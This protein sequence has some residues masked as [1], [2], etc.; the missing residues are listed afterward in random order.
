M[1]WVPNQADWDSAYDLYLDGPWFQARVDELTGRFAPAGQKV[2]VAGAGF[3]YLVDR[4]VTAGYDAW[5]CDASAHVL[6]NATSARIVSGDVLS[7]AS[8][9]DVRDAA[10]L[11]GQQK[12]DLCV[13]EDLLTCFSDAEITTAVANLRDITQAN[14]LHL[15]TCARPDWFT[16]AVVWDDD[17]G[18]YVPGPTAAEQDLAGR[19]PAF[20]WKTLAEWEAILTPPDTVLDTQGMV[21]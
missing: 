14:L 21:P 15:V 12:F 13:T 3:G 10:G 2:L 18:Q 11:K 1:A 4:L 17:L 7:A 20:N 16:D 5:G 8:L 9:D 6:A 19:D